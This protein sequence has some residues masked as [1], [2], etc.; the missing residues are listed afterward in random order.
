MSCLTQFSGPFEAFFYTAKF[1]CS[2]SQKGK[3]THRGR[4][5]DCDFESTKD[6]GE[7]EKS[8]ALAAARRPLQIEKRA[9][10]VRGDQRPVAAHCREYGNQVRAL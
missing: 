9:H 1:I 5:G 3:F 2:Y 6:R 7:A 4:A 8:G 10:S